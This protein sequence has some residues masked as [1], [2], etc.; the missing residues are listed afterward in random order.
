MRLEDRCGIQPGYRITE[1]HSQ[2]R[3]PADM[4]TE[5]KPERP[6]LQ[7]TQAQQHSRQNCIK[8]TQE[9]RA[10][11]VEMEEAKNRR[12]QQH[13]APGPDALHQDLERITAEYQFFSKGAH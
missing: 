4:N 5:R 8:R 11:V 7:V 3:I 13:R 6:C 9:R 10:W 2:T 12:Y 1:Q